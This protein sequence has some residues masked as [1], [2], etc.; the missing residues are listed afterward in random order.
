MLSNCVQ[1]Q[2]PRVEYCVL[3]N[4]MCSQCCDFA[5]QVLCLQLCR[6][7][8]LPTG[9]SIKIQ[10]HIGFPPVLDMQP[11]CSKVLAITM[12]TKHQAHLNILKLTNK[13]VCITFHPD[14]VPLTCHTGPH[15]SSGYGALDSSAK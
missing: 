2:I 7:H 14:F 4:F 12:S 10:G 5:F 13:L 6:A 9:M 3:I 1:A 11:Y 15:V 8:V